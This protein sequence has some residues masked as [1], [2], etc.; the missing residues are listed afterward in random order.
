MEPTLGEIILV[1]F[2]FAPVGWAVCDGS[3]YSISQNS[4]LFSIIGTRFGGN[5]QTNFALPNLTP[6]PGLL[7]LICTNGI[8]PTPD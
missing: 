6:P 3:L 8:Y 2:E 1:G 7:Y 4:A 5:G